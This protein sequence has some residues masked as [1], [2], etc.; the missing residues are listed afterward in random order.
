MI[1]ESFINIPVIKKNIMRIIL[2]SFL[3][4]KF[5]DMSSPKFLKKKYEVYYDNYNN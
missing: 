5:T 2:I 4:L 3:F 1:P